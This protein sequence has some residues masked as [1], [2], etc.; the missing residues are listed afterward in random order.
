[1]KKDRLRLVV[2]RSN[3]YI[4]AQIIN[5]AKGETLVSVNKE[6]DATAAGKKLAEKAKVKKVKQVVFDRAGYKYH[7]DIKKFADAAREGGL[8]F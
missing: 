5:D 2:F 6:T 1:M 8:E 4:Y 3:K 7:G